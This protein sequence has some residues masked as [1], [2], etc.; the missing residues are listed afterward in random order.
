MEG[1][2]AENLLVEESNQYVTFRLDEEEYGVDILNV[3]EI[4]GITNFTRVP[5]LPGFIKGVIN[6]RGIVVPVIDLRIRFNLEAIDYNERTCIVIVKVLERVVG[7]VVDEV[8]EVVEIDE[9]M[10]D[11]T[12]SFG[13]GVSTE[14]IDGLGK[15][16]ERLVV[17]L[18][19]D[20]LLS[21][22]EMKELEKL[23]REEAS[24]KEV[25]SNEE[26]ESDETEEARSE[27]TA[28]A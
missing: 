25:S 10:I 28:Q 12:P 22:V 6:L 23:P 3:Q 24:S 16:D 9:E 7:M 5:Y 15:I 14:F 27:E 13:E 21:E 4:I 18:K 19:V 17:I 1:N 11:E 20:N 26:T 2:V 8:T